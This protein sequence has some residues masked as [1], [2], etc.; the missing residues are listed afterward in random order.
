MKSLRKLY[1]VAQLEDYMPIFDDFVDG[2]DT[3]NK[4]AATLTNSG[5]AALVNTGGNGGVVALAASGVSPAAN[6]QSYLATTNSFFLPLNGQPIIAEAWVQYT[7]LN[8]NAANVFFGL[9]S[10]VAA[11]LLVTANGGMRTTGTILGLFKQGGTSVWQ[12]IARNGTSLQNTTSTQAA[13]LTTYQRLTVEVVD[14]VSLLCTVVFKVDGQILT[15]AN[16]NWIKYI[17]PYSGLTKCQ[18]VLG[19]RNGTVVTGGGELVNMDIWYGQQRRNL[20]V[21]PT[22]P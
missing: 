13:G 6:D 9:A 16:E 10:G 2:P 20:A 11:N 19:V 5:T 7:E 15:D 18:L 17:V 3:T 14:Q 1:Q 8:T 4:Y 22:G 12:A 21:I